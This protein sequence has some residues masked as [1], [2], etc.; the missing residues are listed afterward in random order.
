MN[1]NVVEIESQNRMILLKF[2]DIIYPELLYEKLWINNFLTVIFILEKVSSEFKFTYHIE[3][4]GFLNL[5]VMRHV[6][7]YYCFSVNI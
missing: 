4:V 5:Y 6:D 7:Y 2:T 1:K 3:R